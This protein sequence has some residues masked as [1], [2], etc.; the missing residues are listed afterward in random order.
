MSIPFRNL[1]RIWHRAL[2]SKKIQ[3]DGIWVT[4]D[5]SLVTPTV[6]RRLFSGEYEAHERQLIKNILT[7]DSIVLEVGTG[8]GLISIA[9][10]QLA[11]NGRV[12]S[13]EAN[14]SAEKIIRENYR[15]NGLKPELEMEA[16]TVDGK[17]VDFFIDENILSSSMIDRNRGDNK[18]TVKSQKFSE[19]LEKLQ[20]DTIIM[21]VE[22][23]EVE[24]L[25]NHNL[26]SVENIVVELHPHIVGQIAVEKM[27]IDLR[28]NGFKPIL[29][30][31]KV[32][33]Y[34]R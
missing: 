2:N 29:N 1:K 12:V 18:T 26:S 7:D 5:P 19:V 17:N 22:G 32:W 27:N 9:C 28:S 10:R 25:V 14:P 23:A 33:L 4:T 15:L 16:V 30:S 11:K 8:V 3:I 34:T 20:P 13:Y 24:L 6:R 31:H 21:D